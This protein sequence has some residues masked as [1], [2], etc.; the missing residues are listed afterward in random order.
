MKRF[1]SILSIAILSFASTSCYDDS[2]LWD[3]VNDLDAR[4]ET[5]ETLCTQMNSNLT[6]LTE[7]INAMTMGDVIIGVTPVKENGVEVGYQ[8]L[9]KDGGIVT[10]YHGKNGKDGADG[11]D[12]K[13][14]AD[15]ADG[16]DGANGTNGTNGQDAVA[17]EF[18][19][20][21]DTDGVYYW[22]LNGEFVVDAEGNKVPVTGPAGANGTNG[23][24]GTNGVDGAAGVT[25]QLKIDNEKWLVS[26]DEGKTWE[27]LGA[28]TNVTFGACMFKDVE[29]TETALI[30]TLADGE[31]ISVPIGN[32]FK[33]VLGEFDAT[34]LQYGSDLEIP[35]T[36]E[37]AEGEVVVF[38]LREGDG[39]AVELVEETATSG[40]VTVSQLEATA[41]EKKL[42]VGIF[43][44][45]EDGTTVSKSV[46][47]V[48]GVFATVD[49]NQETYAVEPAGGKVEFKVATNTAFEI[50][51]EEG[52]DW[53]TY[54]PQTKAVEEVALSFKVAANQG[55]DREATVEVVSGDVKLSFTVT[56]EGGFTF[57]ET[58]VGNH[59]VTFM[60]VYGGTGPEYGGG[61]WVDM[62]NKTWWFDETTG[63]GIHA[64]LDNY[65]EIT[66]DGFNADFTQSTGKC[67]NWAGVD[68]KNW[69]TW[70]YNNFNS[71][72]NEYR[73]PDAPKDGSNFYRQIPIGESTWVRDYTVT[74]NTV[75][76][77]DA[78]GKKTVLEVYDVPYTFVPGYNDKNASGNTRTF[79]RTGVKSPISGV[80]ENATLSFHA[81]LNGEKNWDKNGTE[82]DKLF[83]MPRDLVIDVK[84]VDEIPAEAKT[85]E[86]KWVPEFPEVEVVTSLAGTYKFRDGKTVG[87]ND[88]S[89]TA[90]GII[91]QY[92]GWDPVKANINTM[93]DDKFTF[94]ATGTDANGNETGTVTFDKGADGQTWN[95]KLLDNMS[96]NAE[97]D[98]TEMYCIISIEG[99]TTY[100]YD[101]TAGTVKL[102]ADGREYVVDFL[103]P[104]TYKYSDLDV[105]VP[106]ASA[107]GFHLDLGYTEERVA[108]YASK[109]TSNGF[110][111]H[112]VWAR[113]HVFMFDK[114]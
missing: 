90:K 30:L 70:F 12:G 60:W 33:V 112:Y 97:Y 108:G 31:T 93:K 41:T 81:V 95:Y 69:D 2:K 47:L 52:C 66:L 83:Y 59:L 94:T 17:P 23:T 20:K 45:G 21:K 114:E 92:G 53:I 36:I 40:K 86:A 72:K 82:I 61:G 65:L 101:A 99:T 63:H 37:G 27:E 55:E 58:L 64:E 100:V 88:G 87:G 71:S 62:H 10:I 57:E 77:T 4:V 85:T 14:G 107:F 74:P 103:A 50:K 96:G 56:Q 105:T 1:L 73:N 35:Y 49:G 43:A 111:R 79:P 80:N 42:K 102:N 26:Y 106:S 29:L 25:P 110:A 46:R 104:G 6:A 75:T 24:D 22:T 68:G 11:A 15:G 8:L 3:S 113:H 7:L 19:V 16:K 54:D 76:F 48:S 39:F 38:L 5:L 78:E 44:S 18:G 109:S 91:E 32:G 9:L 98:V 67:V 13:D 28:A 34:A 89:I 84:K 51:I